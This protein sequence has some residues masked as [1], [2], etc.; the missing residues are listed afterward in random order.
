MCEVPFLHEC[1]VGGSS[2]GIF[3]IQVLHKFISSLWNTNNT[4]WISIY[5]MYTLTWSNRQIYFVKNAFL[6]VLY[7]YEYL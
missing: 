1:S 7:L 2:L 5:G 6:Q 3:E 4:E